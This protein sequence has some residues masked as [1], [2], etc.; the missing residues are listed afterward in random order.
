MVAVMGGSHVGALIGRSAR[1]KALGQRHEFQIDPICA[2]RLIIPNQSH[3]TQNG[4][5]GAAVA[6]RVAMTSAFICHPF[7]AYHPTGPRPPPPAFPGRPP[8]SRSPRTLP[9]RPASPAQ[10][11]QPPAVAD[12]QDVRVKGPASTRPVT[13]PRREAASELSD[14][15]TPDGGMGRRPQPAKAPGRT[16]ARAPALVMG[17]RSTRSVPGGRSQWSRTRERAERHRIFGAGPLKCDSVWR[18]TA[19]GGSDNGQRTQL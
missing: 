14:A 9:P 5:S 2:A 17:A 4:G 3:A 13:G 19:L 11:T 18:Q 6:S 15:F 16:N 12:D 8:I 1:L 7:P 10:N